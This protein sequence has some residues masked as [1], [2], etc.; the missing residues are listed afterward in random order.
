[1]PLSHREERGDRLL[2]ETYSR[3]LAVLLSPPI[4]D[5]QEEKLMDDTLVHVVGSTLNKIVP[6]VILNKRG[7]VVP[8]LVR[9]IRD[10]PDSKIRDHL[11]Q[12]L[13]NL[14]KVIINKDYYYYYLSITEFTYVT[15]F[16]LILG[17]LPN[18]PPVALLQVV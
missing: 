9:T 12:L 1:M 10:H 6:N 18:W 8:L 7:E 14:H 3:Q 11:L 16:I 5:S 15:T 4:G 17:F 2:P 13:F